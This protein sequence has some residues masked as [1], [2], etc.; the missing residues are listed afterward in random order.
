MG[1]P[2]HAPGDFLMRRK[3]PK[4]HQ[5]PPGSW[6]SGEGGLAPFDP[7]ALCPSGIGCGSI[8]PAAS[9]GASLPSHGLKIE[10]VTPVELEEKNKTD[11]PTNSK[12]QI[13]LLLCLNPYRGGAACRRGS[14]QRGTPSGR[15]FGDFLIG[16][17]VTRGGGAERPLSGGRGGCAPTMGS[18]SQV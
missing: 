6:T 5:E 9:S 4:T 17:K 15:F 14:T 18:R 11:L 1:A 12:W 10:G 7:P 2:P 16:E 13:G 8:E 3:S